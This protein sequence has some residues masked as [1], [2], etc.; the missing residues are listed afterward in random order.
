M[1]PQKRRLLPWLSLLIIYVVW[2]STYLAI[3]VVVQAV[4]PF[5]AAALRFLTAGLVMAGIAGV[6]DRA[7]GWPSRRQWADYAL[8]GVLLLGVGNAFVMWSEQRIPSGIAALIVATVPLWITF[9]DGL[10]PGGQPWTLRVWLGTGLG[11]LGVALV[12]RP[13]GSVTAGHWTG[14]VALQVASLSWTIG[15]LYAQ[16]VRRRL[17][18][19][20]ASAI[21]MLAGAG[22]LF[23]ESRLAGEDLGRF[24]QAPASA[25]LSLVYLA[26]FGSLL[27]F[28]AFAYCLNELPA[29]TV[30]TYAYVN[31]V[32]AV[33]LGA[34]VLGEPL[35]AGLLAGA[36][37]ILAAV[38]FTTMRRRPAPAAAAPPRGP[39]A[40]SSP[41]PREEL[42]REDREVELQ[43]K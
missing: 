11:L 40:P 12:A 7:S 31:P 19:L 23:V 3:R 24:A 26:L 29:S 10:R 17:P 28:T 32:V 30:G 8:V 13:E 2:G 37:L 18:L 39:A 41:P 15:S 6:V 5:A 34:L 43:V 38:V 20:T 14:I 36:A 25:W 42:A 22:V 27:G 21:E 9:L 16:S 35:S 1:S 4:P 33:T